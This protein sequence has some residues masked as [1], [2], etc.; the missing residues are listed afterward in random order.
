MTIVDDLFPATINTRG[1]EFFV[2]PGLQDHRFLCVEIRAGNYTRVDVEDQQDVAAC[3]AD[4]LGTDYVRVCFPGGIGEAIDWRPDGST[5]R[6]GPHRLQFSRRSRIVGA[7]ESFA[8]FCRGETRGMI[9][10]AAADL[11]RDV[12][13][14]RKKRCGRWHVLAVRAW[15]TVTTIVPVV[16]DGI[17][18]VVGSVLR[19]VSMVRGFRGPRPPR[20]SS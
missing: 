2:S 18:R 10:C 15:L 12:R 5:W 16:W 1:K 17:E 13:E 7:L 14:M 8:W 20:P 3:I 19:L 4:V 9:L 11:R 6:S